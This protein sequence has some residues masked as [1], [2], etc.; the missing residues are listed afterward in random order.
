M[1]QNIIY[2]IILVTVL[3]FLF[4]YFMVR[5]QRRQQREHQDLVNELK[6]G[7]MVVTSGGIYGEVESVDPDSVVLRIESGATVRVAKANITNRVQR[8]G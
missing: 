2:V 5:P 1:D 6:S 3:F 8:V 7:D 4:Y